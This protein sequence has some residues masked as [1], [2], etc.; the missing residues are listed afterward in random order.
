MKS[1]NRLPS[2]PKVQMSAGATYGW[3]VSQGSRAFLTG[4]FQFVGSRY[5]QIGDQATGF[6]TVDMNSFAAGGGQTIGG[7]LTQS[8]FTFDPLLPSYSILN[9]RAGL[10]RDTWE[11][12]VFLN[13]LT[14]TRASLALDQERGTR[15]RVGFLTN[16]PRTVGVTLRFNY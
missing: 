13:N 2:V 4:S 12:A 6:G 5:T 10:M 15:A 1:G 8:T 14:D 7:P 9:F 16:Q 3:P 11:V